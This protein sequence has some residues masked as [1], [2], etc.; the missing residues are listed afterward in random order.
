MSVFVINV[1]QTVRNQ[2]D[3]EAKDEDE[4]IDKALELFHAEKQ[5]DIDTEAYNAET[6]PRGSQTE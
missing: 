3:V 6:D 2:Y 5:L 4:A 1:V